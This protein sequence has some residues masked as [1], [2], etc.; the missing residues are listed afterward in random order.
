[1]RVEG[2]GTRLREPRSGSFVKI[3]RLGWPLRN[4]CSSARPQRRKSGSTWLEQHS[5]HR[6]ARGGDVG[7]ATALVG[8]V[9]GMTWP[10]EQAT[11]GIE[12]HGGRSLPRDAISGVS[13]RGYY[14][15]DHSGDQR[16]DRVAAGTA[17]AL[18]EILR[19]SPQLRSC[20]GINEPRP[21]FDYGV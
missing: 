9:L 5:C 2:L 3:A 6:E 19:P 7:S 13:H 15:R 20:V 10:E 16:G 14:L 18:L 17:R 1:M 4:C 11:V 12:D 8:F 21:C